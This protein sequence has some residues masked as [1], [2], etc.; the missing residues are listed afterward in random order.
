[1]KG[2]LSVYSRQT[3]NRR[4]MTRNPREDTSMRPEGGTFARYFRRNNRASASSEK[5]SRL[6]SREGMT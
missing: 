1:M 6:R 5:I 3:R 2:L 4:V